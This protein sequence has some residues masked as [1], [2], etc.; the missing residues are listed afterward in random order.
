[1]VIGRDFTFLE[2]RETFSDG[3]YVL[4]RLTVHHCNM[5]TADMFA[6]VCLS[7]TLS[8]PQPVGAFFLLPVTFDTDVSTAVDLLTS[9][10][11]SA[12][13]P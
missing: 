5:L 3:S 9:S 10:I 7:S 12:C 1:M 13:I 2:T 11:F 8:R 4:V 6:L